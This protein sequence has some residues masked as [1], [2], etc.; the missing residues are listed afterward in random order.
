MGRVRINYLQIACCALTRSWQPALWYILW[1][2]TQPT[3]TRPL[4]IQKDGV[5]YAYG[6]NLTKN[7]CEI[8]G[9][10]GYIGDSDKIRTT[11]KQI[12]FRVNYVFLLFLI[13]PELLSHGKEAEEQWQRRLV[14]KC[15]FHCYHGTQK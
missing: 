1:D 8:Y 10:T 4:A 11:K 15:R 3:A 12:K 13:M 14:M 9:Q 5:W 2:P 6:W 7:I